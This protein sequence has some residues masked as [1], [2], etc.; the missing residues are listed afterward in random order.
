M[1]HPPLGMVV[2]H[3]TLEVGQEDISFVVVLDIEV[4]AVGMIILRQEIP[5]EGKT[6]P[7][8]SEK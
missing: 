3:H 6:L 4:D 5:E 7:K 1:E 8:R 2:I